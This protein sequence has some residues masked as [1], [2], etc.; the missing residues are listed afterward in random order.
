[1]SA[2][3]NAK[4]QSIYMWLELIIDLKS[5]NIVQVK[6]GGNSLV[7]DPDWFGAVRCVLSVKI[8]EEVCCWGGKVHENTTPLK[9]IW[10][11][12]TKMKNIE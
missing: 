12:L 10:G 8:C 3:E 2:V 5:T 6:V 9:C 11:D 1:M 4:R 7:F